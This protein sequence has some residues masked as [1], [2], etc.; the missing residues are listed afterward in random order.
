MKLKIANINLAI[1]LFL[2]KQQV[3]GLII[4]FI[5]SAIEFWRSP[6]IHKNYYLLII[7]VV[8]GTFMT[9]IGLYE[10]AQNNFYVVNEFRYI[11]HLVLI[12]TVAKKYGAASLDFSYLFIILFIFCGLTRGLNGIIMPIYAGVILY[13]ASPESFRGNRGLLGVFS[14]S[15]TTTLGI[16][17][18]SNPFNQVLNI[19][20][21]H[22]FLVVVFGIIAM[23]L[24]QIW[25]RNRELN[26]ESIDRLQLYFAFFS[27]MKNATFMELMFGFGP[28]MNFLELTLENDAPVFVWINSKFGS[29]GVYSYLFHS[30]LIRLSLNYGVITMCLFYVTLARYIDS[31][32]FKLLLVCG[33]FNPVLGTPSIILALIIFG[34]RK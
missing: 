32:V 2:T 29:H 21:P 9:I 20:K 34:S 8:F 17:A 18:A 3:L 4:L 5:Y 15:G 13:L 27:I 30:D 12:A 25:V 6:R 24:Y 10:S 19:R 22:V 14:G 11:L 7:L 33:V 23:V 16:L 28:G 26:L 31:S 1:L